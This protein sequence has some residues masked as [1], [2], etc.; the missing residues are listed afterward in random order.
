MIAFLISVAVTSYA[1]VLYAFFTTYVDPGIF[2]W[3]KSAEWVIMVFFG[4]VNS[5]TGSI[6]G[7]VILTALPEVLRFAADY[8]TV[9]YAVLVLIIIN[10]KP[11]GLFGEYELSL[12]NLLKRL[13]GKKEERA[14][15]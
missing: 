12:V 14:N 11:T 10:F 2:G 5:L 6:I 15:A 1:G 13:S 7:T 9:F 3:K 4:G 8:R